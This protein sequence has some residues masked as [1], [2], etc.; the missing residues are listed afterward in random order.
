[1]LDGVTAMTSCF[2]QSA[3]PA[4]PADPTL[5]ASAKTRP[6]TIQRP[7]RRPISALMCFPL[8]ATHAFP[9][10]PS[11][12]KKRRIAHGGCGADPAPT[13]REEAVLPHEEQRLLERLDR[14]LHV[15]LGV[16]GRHPAVHLAD[17]RTIQ[18]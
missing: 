4:P 16:D 9:T 2:G 12:Q 13:S 7:N 3:A 14:S 17:I 11:G 6:P 8:A 5:A 18:D 15:L 10:C 1:M